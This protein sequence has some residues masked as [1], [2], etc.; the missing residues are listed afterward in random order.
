MNILS[1]ITSNRRKPH[2]RQLQTR[3]QRDVSESDQITS[4]SPTPS[5]GFS[6]IGHSLQLSLIG[7]AFCTAF[8][9][10]AVQPLSTSGSKVLAGGQV[11]SFAGNGLFWSNNNWGGENSITLAW[12]LR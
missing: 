1:M 11:A 12:F 5:S 9:A 8:D 7:L 3:G 6:R 4:E 2:S 10:S